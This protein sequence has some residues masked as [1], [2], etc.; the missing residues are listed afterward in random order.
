MTYQ[1]IPNSRVKPLK[2][3]LLTPGDV[4]QIPAS[5]LAEERRHWGRVMEKQD[6]MLPLMIADL[7]LGDV[8]PRAKR[9]LEPVG[10]GIAIT[11][12]WELVGV[13]ANRGYS[14]FA[15]SG[16]AFSQFAR[17]TGMLEPDRNNDYR[18]DP[19][20]PVID[21]GTDT[22][23]HA[24]ISRMPELVPGFSEDH[25]S[26]NRPVAWYGDDVSVARIER[27][28]EFSDGALVQFQEDLQLPEPP[29]VSDFYT[30]RPRLT[31]AYLNEVPM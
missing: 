29:D 9:P 25:F 11:D 13:A 23:L 10:F 21:V 26:P 12:K 5:R 18:P 6:G 19:Q 17:R 22:A 3:K 24:H 7:M 1:R 30:V 4:P 27:R 31:T 8:L 2:E 14:G 28:P 15:L 16:L 20:G